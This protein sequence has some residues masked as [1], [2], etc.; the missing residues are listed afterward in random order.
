MPSRDEHSVITGPAARISLPVSKD[1][2]GCYVERDSVCVNPKDKTRTQIVR[3]IRKPGFTQPRETC[4]NVNGVVL[5]RA[6]FS[7]LHL[8][9]P[10]LEDH[11]SRIF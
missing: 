9:D 4:S 6:E 2:R 10:I 3:N 11:Y 8:F 1:R 7:H 5:E